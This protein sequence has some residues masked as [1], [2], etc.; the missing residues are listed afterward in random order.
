MKWFQNPAYEDC[1][2][3]SLKQWTKFW[4]LLASFKGLEH[5]F[6]RLWDHRAVINVGEAEVGEFTSTQLLDPLKAVTSPGDFRFMLALPDRIDADGLKVPGTS[7]RIVKTK[8][9]SQE[10]LTY[11]HAWVLSSEA[12]QA[13]VSEDEGQTT[14]DAILGRLHSKSVVFSSSHDCPGGYCD[15]QGHPGTDVHYISSGKKIPE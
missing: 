3:E 12:N 8:N 14:L 10:D 15:M 4:Q 6:V 5:L 2:K 1:N 11:Y 13:M 7:C 9:L